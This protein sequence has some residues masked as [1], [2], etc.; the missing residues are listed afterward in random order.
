MRRICSRQSTM[1]DIT[2]HDPHEGDNPHVSH[3]HGDVDVKT[4]SQFGIALALG[5]VVI[6]FMMYG[7]FVWFYDRESAENATISRGLIAERPTRP[8]EPTLQ[9]NPRLELRDLRDAEEKTLTGYRWVDPD[10][11]IVSIPIDKAIEA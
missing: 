2:R 8:P 1:D 10:K 4:I 3:E 5:T 6:V 11:G 9:V 7:L